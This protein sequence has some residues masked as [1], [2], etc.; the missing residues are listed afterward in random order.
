MN[1]GMLETPA[2]LQ[3]PTSSKSARTLFLLRNKTRLKLATVFHMFLAKS[4]HLRVAASVR[5]YKILYIWSLRL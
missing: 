2:S 4:R 5:D 3:L 1:L